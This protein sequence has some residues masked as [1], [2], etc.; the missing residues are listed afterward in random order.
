MYIVNIMKDLKIKEESDEEDCLKRRIQRAS[1]MARSMQVIRLCQPCWA[2]SMARS[3][4][5][6]RLCQPCWANILCPSLHS[7]RWYESWAL[8]LPILPFMRAQ[9]KRTL[10][11]Q[12][13]GWEIQLNTRISGRGVPMDLTPSAGLMT[14]MFQSM[15]FCGICASDLLR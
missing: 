3:M 12:H 11:I 13:K 10:N 4:Q 15:T 1:S 5:V 9:V 7:E 8:L 2:S 6:I 14:K